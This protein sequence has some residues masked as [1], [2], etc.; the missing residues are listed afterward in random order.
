MS[1]EYFHDMAI[2]DQRLT[3]VENKVEKLEKVLK[4]ILRLLE[5]L[6]EWQQR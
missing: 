1:K 5:E 2:V 3:S 4:K 6:K